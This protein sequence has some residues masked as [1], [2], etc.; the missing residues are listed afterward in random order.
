MNFNP[1][2]IGKIILSII[3]PLFLINNIVLASVGIPNVDFGG[4]QLGM[5]LN[6]LDWG[7]TSKK[8][9]NKT[10]R[11]SAIGNE[12]KIYQ[13][14]LEQN[15]ENTSIIDNDYVNKFSKS[16]IKQHGKPKST[17]LPLHRGNSRLWE[18]ANSICNKDKVSKESPCEPFTL[19]M[20]YGF[21]E[22]KD[23]RY[24]KTGVKSPVMILT[25]T[26][27]KIKIVKVNYGLV[28]SNDAQLS[29]S[30]LKQYLNTDNMDGI[31]G[32]TLGKLGW[33]GPKKRVK[34]VII[35]VKANQKNGVI[36]Q[37]KMERM[38]KNFGIAQ[39]LI[40]VQFVQA[41]FD[42]YGKIDTWV[43]PLRTSELNITSNCN[44]KSGSLSN[45][46]EPYTTRFCYGSCKKSSKRQFSQRGKNTVFS[47]NPASLSIVK[48]DYSLFNSRDNSNFNQ[49]KKADLKPKV[50]KIEKMVPQPLTGTKFE[51]V[52]FGNLDLTQ[53]RIEFGKKGSYITNLD[54]RCSAPLEVDSHSKN[55]VKLK[56]LDSLGGKKGCGGGEITMT[57]LKD[58]EVDV[59]RTH[60]YRVGAQNGTLDLGDARL[61]SLRYM[62]DN[63]PTKSQIR[64]L[65]EREKIKTKKIA[66]SSKKPFGIFVDNYYHNTYILDFKIKLL[67]NWKI[68]SRKNYFVLSQNQELTYDKEI[69]L[70]PNNFYRAFVFQASK[71][72]SIT[73]RGTGL[74]MGNG[75]PYGSYGQSGGRARV[76]IGLE[77]W[78]KNPEESFQKYL[79]RRNYETSN[80]SSMTVSQSP[81]MYSGD[82]NIDGKTFKVYEHYSRTNRGSILSRTYFLEVGEFIYDFN[83]SIS[84][85]N[86]R[87]LDFNS[88]NIMASM[89][90]LK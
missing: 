90:R 85:R 76:I 48:N 52:W 39:G 54:E 65:A 30:P 55:F 19:R 42:K 68:I 72:V 58:D 24:F 13:L 63:P 73:S 87:S 77:I 31:L 71:D 21:C 28:K 41:A 37:V 9:G 43:F 44:E 34:D 67:R 59:I 6:K 60:K 11:V 50:S 66:E 1:K 80:S 18:K 29:I 61:S 10:Y 14:V 88:G 25:V 3:L 8:I 62:W 69:E 22:K 75:L 4:A 23:K 70:E 84:A 79:A 17:I 47:I 78:R 53:I 74:F 64:K 45:A 32:Q 89:I 36:Y 38:T 82:E 49:S 16:F 5:K 26:P 7:S 27:G 33:K 46:C 51:G 81:P 56:E 20:C 83:V 35:S 86:V 40:H 2:N 57:L 15:V 12:G